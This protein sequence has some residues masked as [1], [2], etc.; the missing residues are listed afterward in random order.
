MGFW[1]QALVAKALVRLCCLVL[2][3]PA[4]ICFLRRK[5]SLELGMQCAYLV[6]CIFP[7]GRWGSQTAMPTQSATRRKCSGRTR[8]RRCRLPASRSHGSF[9]SRSPHG[10]ELGTEPCSVA[11][12]LKSAVPVLVSMSCFR[13]CSDLGYGVDHRGRSTPCRGG[14]SAGE[15]SDLVSFP[16]RPYKMH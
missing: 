14:P 4:R 9:V 13:K 16:E 2:L 3:G 12:P 5:K 7:L 10:R 15:C 6:S 8:V 11:I 1:F